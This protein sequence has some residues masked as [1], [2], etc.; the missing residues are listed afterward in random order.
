[1][2]SPDRIL[3]LPGD[4][5]SWRAGYHDARPWPHLV[6][7]GVVDEAVA[8]EI[9][10]E[11]AATPPALLVRE[12]S[13]RVKKDAAP[14]CHSLGATAERLFGELADSRFLEFLS[15][16]TGVSGL[17]ADPELY[18]AGVFMTRAGGWQRVHEDFPRHPATGL[19]NRVAVLLYCCEWSPEWGGELELWPKDMSRRDKVVQPAPGRLVVFETNRTTRHGVTEVSAAATHPRVVVATRYY[20]AEPPPVRPSNPLRRSFRRPTERRRDVLPTFSEMRDYLYSQRRGERRIE[21]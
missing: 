19:W 5:P 21:G 12:S 20:S 16:L 13:R 1:L 2:P 17:Q 18:N 7:D 6:L 8:A 14:D 9:A 10:A 3:R 11:A 15:R 4:P